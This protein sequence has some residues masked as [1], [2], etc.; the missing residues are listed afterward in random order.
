MGRDHFPNIPVGAGM[1]FSKG[2]MLLEDCEGTFTWAINGTGGD[3]VHAFATAAAFT[4]TYGMHLKTR[5]TAAAEDDYID[6]TK[7]MSYPQ[8]GLL[9]GRYRMRSA[10]ISLLKQHSLILGDDD[11]TAQSAGQLGISPNLTQI[12]YADAAGAGQVIAAAA[13]LPLDSQWWT[14]ELVIDCILHQYI[15]AT[16]NGIRVDL[17]GIPLKAL[18]ASTGR[19][20][21]INLDVIAEGAAAAEVHLD[22]IYVGEY[23]ES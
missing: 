6:V 3:D 20:A 16:L 7:L 10:D 11:G 18:G 17:A 5:T 21:W 2:I 22:N 15:S 14:I 12:W 23:L 13:G 4:G 9:V 1:G 8:S 19:A